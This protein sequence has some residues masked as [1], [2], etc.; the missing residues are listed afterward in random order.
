MPE[1]FENYF[2]TSTPY[3][4]RIKYRRVWKRLDLGLS[5]IPPPP[6]LCPHIKCDYYIIAIDDLI[7]MLF[8]FLARNA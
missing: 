8:N 1:V 7:A 5:Q 4:V 6:L 2:D 3:T